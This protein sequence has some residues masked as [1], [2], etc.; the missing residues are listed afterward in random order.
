MIHSDEYFSWGKEKLSI[1]THPSINIINHSSNFDGSDCTE[2]GLYCLHDIKE[3]STLFGVP[4]SSIFTMDSI[5]GTPLQYLLSFNMRE[6]DVLAL[7]LLYFKFHTQSQWDYHI[8]LLPSAYHSIANYTDEELELITGTN[9]Y[10]TAKQWKRQIREDYEALI[11][12]GI[13]ENYSWLT[14]DSYVWALCTIWSRFITITR[15]GQMRRGMIPIV[16]ILNHHPESKVSHIF[17]DSDDTFY[18]VS[19]QSHTKG[20]EIFLNYGTANNARL[21]MLYGF[22][23]FDNP[24]SSVD[25]WASMSP[26]SLNY[27]MKKEALDRL[28]V[29]GQLPFVVDKN[30][31]P[32]TLFA[33]LRIQHADVDSEEFDNVDKLIRLESK[34]ADKASEERIRE[35]IKSVLVDMIG[36]YLTDIDADEKKIRQTLAMRRMEHLKKGGDSV[37]GTELILPDDRELNALIL[38]YSEKRILFDAL[39]KLQEQDTSLV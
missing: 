14:Y 16:D 28:G 33:F 9:L 21:L 36:G 19:A 18:V 6:D 27:A 7:S 17:N 4:Y 25:I 3:N 8:K 22:T 31:V 10:S 30:G 38:V 32:A 2:R 20:E 34:F 24:F 13:K 37:S 15:R 1:A 39:E 35:I 23:I 26:S 11:D 29:S 12:L 5:S